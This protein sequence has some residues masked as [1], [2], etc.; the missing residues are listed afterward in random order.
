MSIQFV[1]IIPYRD[2]EPHKFFF[3]K[4]MEYILE[5][6]DKSTYLLLFVHQ[7]NSLSFNRGAMKNIGFLYIKEKYPTEYQNII[8]MIKTKY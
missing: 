6:Y 5:D 4:H 3:E 1:F 2:R 7:N 8:F